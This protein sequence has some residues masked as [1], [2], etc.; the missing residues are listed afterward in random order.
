MILYF[1][2]SK[3]FLVIKMDFTKFTDIY[4]FYKKTG[5][6]R[7]E[8]FNFLSSELKKLEIEKLEN[9]SSKG[10]LCDIQPDL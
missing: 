6:S 8:T 7:E 10:E 2:K 3:I 1:E 4:D 5:K 9:K